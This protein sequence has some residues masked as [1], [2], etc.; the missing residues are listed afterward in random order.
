MDAGTPRSVFYFTI[1][2]KCADII[3]QYFK[4]NVIINYG[5]SKYKNE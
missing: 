2:L 1:V 4:N 3:P 5:K